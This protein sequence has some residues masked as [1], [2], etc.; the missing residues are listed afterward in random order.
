MPILCFRVFRIVTNKIQARVSDLQV[1]NFENEACRQ[2]IVSLKEADEIWANML[3]KRRWLP[4]S[5]FTE[6]LT[7]K[8]EGLL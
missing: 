6:F 5:S 4:T 7:L 1:G 2:G 3:K 8:Q